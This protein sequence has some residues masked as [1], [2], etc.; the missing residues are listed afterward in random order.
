MQLGFY[1]NQSRCTGCY[2]CRV[3][4]KDWHDVP[5]GPAS[6]IRVIT[7]EKGKFPNLSLSNL[8]NAC[9]HCADPICATVCPA[10][11]ISKREEDGIVIVD[12]EKCRQTASC[13]IIS[14]YK[15]IP[16]GDMQSPC[17]IACPAG[18]NA[19]GYI[20]LVA[21]GK[22]REALELIRQ[23]LP[24]PSVCGRVCQHPC[25]TACKRQELDEPIAIMDLKRFVT[26]QVLSMPEPLPITESQKV[27]I[28]GSGPAGLAAAWE[29]AKN[30]YPTTIFEALPVAGG[31]LAVGIPDYRLPKEILLRDLD[32]LKALG[33]KIKTSSPIGTGPTLN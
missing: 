26:D 25:E 1:V 33:I 31:M 21:R 29:L 12:R 22:F 18:V 13:G 11:A 15:D 8:F 24:L 14:N 16:F 27:A 28:I 23:D 30:G 9:Y 19:Q 7:T 10:E 3:A 32:Y 5:A 4:C 17:T 20:A 6:W 2:T